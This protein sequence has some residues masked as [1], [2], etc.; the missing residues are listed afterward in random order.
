MDAGLDSLGAVELRNQLEQLSGIDLPSTVLTDYPTARLLSTLFTQH[1]EQAAATTVAT[2]V[3]PTPLSLSSLSQRLVGAFDGSSSNT[4]SLALLRP[5]RTAEEGAGVPLVIM[6]SFLGDESG[7]ER[8]W[9]LTLNDRPIY[10]LRHRFLAHSDAEAEATH[11]QL[12]RCS[13]I[14]SPPSFL[15]SAQAN[16][17]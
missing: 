9:K 7:Y 16:L 1:N 11:Y 4:P 3:D 14:M 8:L 10:A 15:R 12:R 2:A 5:A 17:I 13:K 6:H